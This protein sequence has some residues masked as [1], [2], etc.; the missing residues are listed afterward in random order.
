[1]T[2]EAFISSYGY[3]AVAVGTFIEGETVL[4]LGGVAAQG[5]LLELPWVVLAAFLG[6]LTGDQLYFHIGR[7]KGRDLLQRRPGWQAK[8]ERV[9][10]LLERH[11]VWLILGYRFLYGLRTVIPFAIGAARVPPLRF[12]LWDMMGVA[13][14]ATTVG[15]L[16]YL[17]GRAL[18]AVV[19]DIKDYQLT[20]FGV[21]AGLGL[22]V[23]LVRLWRRRRPI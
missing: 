23:W 17:F 16:G 9:F 2:I 3:F 21:A 18:E 6:T 1:M 14:W 10:V 15:T 19:G 7:W 22:L 11:Q 5:G 13:L 20:L 12:L 4:I 8:S